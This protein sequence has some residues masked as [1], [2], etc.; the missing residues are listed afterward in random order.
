MNTNI[1]NNPIVH[2]LVTAVLF[3]LSWFVTSGNPVLTLTVGSLAKG[4]Y[5]WLASYAD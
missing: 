1:L 5:T 4:A 3:A 2:I